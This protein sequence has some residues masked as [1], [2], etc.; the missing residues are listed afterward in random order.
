VKTFVKVLVSILIGILITLLVMVGMWFLIEGRFMMVDLVLA[1][2]GSTFVAVFSPLILLLTLV[3][4]VS[5][6]L[7][8]NG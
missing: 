4:S 5:A 8:I 6:W 3:F 1:L 2:T 7:L